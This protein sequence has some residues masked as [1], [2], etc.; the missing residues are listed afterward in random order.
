MARWQYPPITLLIVR[1]WW[2]LHGAMTSSASKLSSPDWRQNE[3][4]ASFMTLSNTERPVTVQD[5]EVFADDLD[6]TRAAAIYQEHGC[7]VVRGLMKPYLADI[8]RDIEATA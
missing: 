7:L 2:Q 3:K 4:G 1:A 8:Q 6:V 5:L